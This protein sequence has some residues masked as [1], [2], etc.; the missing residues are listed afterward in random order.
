MNNPTILH[1]LCFTVPLI[2]ILCQYLIR[3]I[4]LVTL[5]TTK[6]FAVEAVLPLR[7]WYPRKQAVSHASQHLGVWRDLT[8]HLPQPPIEVQWKCKIWDWVDLDF[9][10]N[11]STYQSS[12]IYLSEAR[13]IY[14][15]R[16]VEVGISW[17]IYLT[18]TSI[19]PSSWEFPG[20]PV[21]RTLCF[22]CKGHGFNPWSGN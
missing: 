18:Y 19:I 9:N 8:E 7:H 15:I 10:S 6:R 17:V 2:L 1:S 13:C 16:I 3:K 4:F 22:H 11:S 21:V 14:L 5:K 12:N 20:S